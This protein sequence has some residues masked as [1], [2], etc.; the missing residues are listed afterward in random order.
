MILGKDFEKAFDAPPHELLK[1]KLFRHNIGGK[2]FKC[3]NS[4]KRMLQAT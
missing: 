3:I 1:C 4:F 2:T